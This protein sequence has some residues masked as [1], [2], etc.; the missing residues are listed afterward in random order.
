MLQGQVRSGRPS[1]PTNP[2]ENDVLQQ[3][4]KAAMLGTW[5][6][7]SD[8]LL[9]TPRRRPSLS[10]SDR[11]CRPR[12]ARARP[13]SAPRRHTGRALFIARPKSVSWRFSLLE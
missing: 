8:S 3:C 4:D 6:I 7:A 9:P 10:A 11:P 1:S 12:P 5:T 2:K 13:R